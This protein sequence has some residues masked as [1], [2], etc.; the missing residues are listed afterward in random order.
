MLVYLPPE[1]PLS[2]LSELAAKNGCVLVYETNISAANKHQGGLVV[3]KPTTDTERQIVA[4]RA[5][6]ALLV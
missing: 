4:T 5:K 2:D 6:V 3:R 1:I